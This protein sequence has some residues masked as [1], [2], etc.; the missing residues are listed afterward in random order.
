MRAIAQVQKR[1]V[2]AL[3]R[4]ALMGF[5]EAEEVRIKRNQQAEQA[6]ENYQKTG[7]HATGDAV[8]AWLDTWGTDTPLPTPQCHK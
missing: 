4:E 2:H 6:W 3:A 7:L 8:M 1:P 5:I